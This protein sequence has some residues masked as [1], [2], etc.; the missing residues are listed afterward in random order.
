MTKENRVISRARR[1]AGRAG[2]ALLVTATLTGGSLTVP[3]CANAFPFLPSNGSLGNVEGSNG[4]GGPVTPPVDPGTPPATAK[5][6]YLLN[7][8]PSY[9]TNVKRMVDATGNADLKS[10]LDALLKTPVSQ[11]LGGDGV[12]DATQL[13]AKGITEKAIP[14]LTFYH[15][16]D[17]DLGSHSGGGAANAA[18]YRTW[19]DAM[20]TAIAAGP[21]IVILEP[22]ALAQMPDMKDAAKENE[23][24]DL[25]AYGIK[26]LSAN[27]KTT[28]YLDIGTAGWRSVDDTAALMKKV[29]DKGADI[30]HVSANV[31][32]FVSEA[33]TKTYVDSI[34]QKFGKQLKMMVDNSRNGAVVPG[35]EWCNPTAQRLG[36]LNDVVF[37]PASAVE[38]VFVK[39]PGESDGVCGASTKP[40]GVFDDALMLLQLGVSQPTLR[41]TRPS[42]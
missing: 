31:S 13:V 14:V 9:Y 37:D 30:T 8:R 29:A 12:A 36:T 33:K 17:R 16:P 27:P 25:L 1:R 11:W 15:I 26:K 7:A 4:S 32:N 2:A 10:K 40:A 3:A 18:A 35:G 23:R 20:A 24:A 21:S 5:L 6:P 42:R 39:T 19:I 28:V 22:D 41:S 34:Q 38:G